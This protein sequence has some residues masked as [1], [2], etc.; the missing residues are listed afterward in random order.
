MSAAMSS[1]ASGETSTLDKTLLTHISHMS[2]SPSSRGDNKKIQIANMDALID[3]GGA[4]FPPPPAAANDPPNAR[5]IPAYNAEAVAAIDAPEEGGKRLFC[6]GDDKKPA[7][8]GAATSTAAN[9]A[10]ASTATS[11]A[12]FTSP[13][14]LTDM[15]T[16]AMDHP[17]WNNELRARKYD[18]DEYVSKLADGSNMWSPPPKNDDSGRAV[19]AELEYLRRALAERDE[20]LEKQKEQ[21]E[22]QKGM[23]ECMSM[24]INEYQCTLGEVE[25]EYHLHKLQALHEKVSIIILIFLFTS[26]LGFSSHKHYTLTAKSNANAEGKHGKNR[27]IGTRV[28]VTR[29]GWIGSCFSSCPS[30]S[31]LV[32]S[33]LVCSSSFQA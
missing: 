22:E 31:C 18:E 4:K 7:P 20:Q 1:F 28:T 17:I 8:F 10:N 21:L 6:L 29:W 15:T 14:A 5:S 30:S 25:E 23:M 12:A 33:S 13:A 19:Q 27:N 2:I 11:A 32:C 9:A 3:Q 24:Q 26:I 16:A